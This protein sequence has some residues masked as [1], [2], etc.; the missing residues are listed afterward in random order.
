MQLFSTM[1]I[2]P[3]ESSLSHTATVNGAC[4]RGPHALEDAEGD[5][6]Y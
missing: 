3:A 1:P 4:C 2:P 5:G 6:T